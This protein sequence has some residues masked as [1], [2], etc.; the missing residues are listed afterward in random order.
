MVRQGPRP[1]RRRVPGRRP[2]SA[3]LLGGPGA[4]ASAAS[5][6]WPSSRELRRSRLSAGMGLHDLDHGPSSASALGRILRAPR[7]DRRRSCSRL[8][9]LDWFSPLAFGL[10]V[11]PFTMLLL[12]Y[13][14]QLMLRGTGT[15]LQI[16]ADPAAVAAARELA[17]RE[18]SRCRRSSRASPLRRTGS[19]RP[20]PRSSIH[21]QCLFGTAAPTA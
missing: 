11:V 5:G 6:S 18:A 10:A 1:C 12:A 14:A 19:C 4:A 15:E 8:D 21:E 7:R 20:A 16:P 13:E 2:S 3:G 9:T 17:A